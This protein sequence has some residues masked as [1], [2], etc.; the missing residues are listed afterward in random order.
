MNNEFK[1]TLDHRLAALEWKKG[2]SNAVLMQ[3]KGKT[4]VKKKW[5]VALILLIALLA[6]TLTAIA[7]GI[8]INEFTS[9]VIETENETGFLQTW[10]ENAKQKMMTMMTAYGLVGDKAHA[11]TLLDSWRTADDALQYAMEIGREDYWS[12]EGRAWADQVLFQSGLLPAPIHLL[13]TE[14]A[15]GQVQALQAAQ[16][17]VA[18]E[19]PDALGRVESFR[20]YIRY[21]D[22]H[23]GKGPHW[24]FNFDDNETTDSYLIRIYD[25]G[26]IETTAYVPVGLERLF[27]NLE[28]KLGDFRYWAFSDKYAFWLGLPQMIA[29]EKAAR[30]EVSPEIFEIRHK[31]YGLPNESDTTEEEAIERAFPILKAKADAKY[32]SPNNYKVCAEFFRPQNGEAYWAISYYFFGANH[33]T[34]QVS[35][36]DGSA[37]LAFDVDEVA[38]TQTGFVTTSAAYREK[39]ETQKGGQ[40]NWTLEEKQEYARLQEAEGAILDNWRNTL[41]EAGDISQEKA[42]AIAKATAEENGWDIK[43]KRIDVSFVA[44]GSSNRIWFIEFYRLEEFDAIFI[45]IDAVSGEVVKVLGPGEANG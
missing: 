33:Y 19:N 42:I 6:I 29:S 31:E 13:P 14:K 25:S 32:I 40:R 24:W 2:N 39:L 21:M 20:T 44:T 10:D 7:A 22:E 23:D 1:N 43:D 5:S 17:A 9:A 27:A 4:K 45:S 28:M 37:S 26:K 12:I 35:A 18:K 3:L 11:I 16:A 15:L 34:V 36:A 41:P 30:R 38:S 8:L